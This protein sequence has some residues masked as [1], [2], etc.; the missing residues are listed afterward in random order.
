M[1][2]GSDTPDQAEAVLK[3]LGGFV[4]DDEQ[5]EGDGMFYVDL[6]DDLA[7]DLAK[8]E[9]L[10]VSTPVSGITAQLFAELP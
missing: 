9:F 4:A 5:E 10:N 8:D 2:A 1:R 3:M 7:E 6:P